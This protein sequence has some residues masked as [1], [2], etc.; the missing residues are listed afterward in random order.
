MAVESDVIEAITLAN[1]DSLR[2]RLEA[3]DFKT[4]E[5]C[6]ADDM[7]EILTLK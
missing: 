2:E 5:T 4:D 3:I 7:R 1:G 6:S